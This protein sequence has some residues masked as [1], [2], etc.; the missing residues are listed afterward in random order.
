[1]GNSKFKGAVGKKNV[2]VVTAVLGPTDSQR[3]AAIEQA[4]RKFKFDEARNLYTR[5]LVP[6]EAT[7][8]YTD[9]IVVVDRETTVTLGEV[10]RATTIVATNVDN[11]EGWI[12]FLLGDEERLK[13]TAHP[14]EPV[15]IPLPVAVAID[16]I[17]LITGP[18]RSAEWWYSISGF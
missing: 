7:R 5:T 8:F 14:Y 3:L 6:R 11:E 18:S 12:S 2:N 4:V 15:V 17:R 13:F 10:I 9:F 1:M 16:G